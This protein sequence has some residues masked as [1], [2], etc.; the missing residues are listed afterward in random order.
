MRPKQPHWSSISHSLRSQQILLAR[1]WSFFRALLRINISGYTRGMRNAR[2]TIW[3]PDNWIERSRSETRRRHLRWLIRTP[4]DEAVFAEQAWELQCSKS[5]PNILFYSFFSR[6]LT[7]NSASI[8]SNYIAEL[9]G[10]I[11]LDTCN[12]FMKFLF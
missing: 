1:W 4:L 10:P 11:P 6:I 9:S 2:S 5:R 12:I 8:L 3:L 7:L